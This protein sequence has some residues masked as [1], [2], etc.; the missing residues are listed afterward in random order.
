MKKQLRLILF[1]LAVLPLVASANGPV[2]QKV[3]DKI[4]IDATPQE[5]WALV[6]DFSALHEWLS[7]IK[8]TRMARDN[9]RVLILDAEGEPTVTEDLESRDE[10]RMS[11]A[12]RIVD[13]DVVSTVDFRGTPYDVPVVPVDDYWSAIQ[14]RPVNGGSEVTW[15]GEFYRVY[16]G[17]YYSDE[18][19]YPAGLGDVEG[20]TTIQTIYRSGLNNLKRMLEGS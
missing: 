20:V 5:V 14:V 1:V 8:A 3:V 9:Q 16:R 15:T 19:R 4:L 12:Y 7:A 10:A 11:I 13:Q 6:G 2:R 17:D 18:P